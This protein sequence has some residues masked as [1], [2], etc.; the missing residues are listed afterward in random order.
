MVLPRLGVGLPAFEPHAG[1]D[2]LLAVATAAERLGYH[3]AMV[4]E[5]WLVP[6]GDDWRNAAG[7]PI[8]H[9]Y[10]PL[11]TLAWVAAHTRR[12]RLRTGVVNA[13]FQP[14]V[15]L[16][17]RLAT[18]DRLS[19]GRLDPS[20]GQGWLPAEFAA[21]GVSTARPGARFEDYLA[22]LRA[23]WG[24]DP[25]EHAGP[26]YPIARAYLGPKPA[27]GRLPLFIGAVAP[28]A[29]A[30]AAR[31]GDGFV[32][33]C[34]DWD[35]TLAQLDWYRQAGGAGPVILR[36]GPTD[37]NH[38]GPFGANPAAVVDDLTR[39]AAAGIDEVVWDLS[40]GGL[41]PAAQ[42]RAYTALAE[43]ID[44]PARVAGLAASLEH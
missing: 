11:E 44:L 13:L 34:R 19:G 8:H 21:A 43:A 27:G 42:V 20:L 14:P 40:L 3:S 26:Y 5:R 37:P 6:A 24:P 18:L 1:P 2:A 31:L 9:S 39:A 36:A 16:A 32:V 25:V 28:A 38:T 7:L 12:L 15:L 33:G 29:V 4:G 22:A 30:R 35:S 17:R 41:D 10:D 23:C